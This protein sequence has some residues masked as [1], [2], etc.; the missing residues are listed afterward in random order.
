[1]KTYFQRSQPRGYGVI[2]IVLFTGIISFIL[3]Q[4]SYR[5]SLRTLETQRRVQLQLDYNQKEQ[6]FLTAM[7]GLTPKFLANNMIDGSLVDA[8]A[9]PHSTITGLTVEAA[10]LSRLDG[11]VD[12][13]LNA[14]GFDL[15]NTISANTGLV[16]A[17]IPLE[18]IG[19]LPSISDT[20]AGWEGDTSRITGA[21]PPTMAVRGSSNS[22]LPQLP[23]DHNSATHQTFSND[24]IYL[25]PSFTYSSNSTGPL[26]PNFFAD[27][28]VYTHYNLIPYPNIAFG[29]GT[30]GQPFVARQNWWRIFMHTESADRAQTDVAVNEINSGDNRLDFID[31]EYILS[32]YEIPSQ[33][34]ISA[35]TL[36]DL[37]SF[38]D[39]NAW[40]A[41]IQIDGG[42]Y[43]TGANTSGI[44]DIERLST[45]QEATITE[46]TTI[47][48]AGGP[49]VGPG[50]VGT[51]TDFEIANRQFFPIAKSSDSS[52]SLFVGLAQG[53]AFFDRFAD[54]FTPDPTNQ[55][56]SYQN[57][58]QYSR[59]CNQTA[60]KLDIIAAAGNTPTALRFTYL[61]NARQEVSIDLSNTA[62]GINFWPASEGDDG[63]DTFPFLTQV[64]AGDEVAIELHVDR[65]GAYLAGLP[66]SAGLGI[67]HSITIN[68]D[69]ISG[70]VEGVLPPANPLDNESPSVV[71]D[72]TQDL[73]AFPEGFSF[74]SNLRTFIRTDVNLVQAPIP[75]GSGLTEFYPPVSIFAPEIRYGTGARTGIDIQGRIGSLSNTGTGINVL[76][77]RLADGTVDNDAITAQLEDVTHPSQIPPV[78][79]MNWLVVL[80]R[81]TR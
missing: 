45:K 63:F 17:R 44:L 51:K 41:N 59:G 67:N 15:A 22:P 39:G 52:K 11:N 77:L 68:P 81:V 2:L 64:L 58:H 32:V 50:A 33:L 14:L 76:D 6:A 61:N 27:P 29:Y 26:H 24:R 36:L 78:N 1:M 8:A 30:P 34:A 56:A 9:D 73:T 37:G 13:Q 25:S 60:M 31:R 5:V 40:N 72:G 54:G 42:V 4:Q 75:A 3:F 74:V 35:N 16:N 57:F 66:N 43:A 53:N 71:L 46:G 23:N 70:A 10:N 48:R 49:Q 28:T 7:V 62:D 20:P 38:R 18:Y 19:I 79:I 55:R 80:N 12:D 65:L 47:G 21:F 69:Y